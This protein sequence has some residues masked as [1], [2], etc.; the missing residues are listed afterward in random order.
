TFA[1]PGKESSVAFV[2]RCRSWGHAIGG[3]SAYLAQRRLVQIATMGAITR[4]KVEGLFDHLDTWLAPRAAPLLAGVDLR[5]P[6][7]DYLPQQRPRLVQRVLFQETM[8]CRSL[9]ELER[10]ANR[11]AQFLCRQPA[12]DVLRAR[13]LLFRRRVE[14][15]EAEQAAILDVKRSD[16]ES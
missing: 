12:I 7:H 2:S 16:R 13:P 14:H 11:H 5:V 8:R 6:H 9:G 3:E 10:A 4:E 15:R 1:P